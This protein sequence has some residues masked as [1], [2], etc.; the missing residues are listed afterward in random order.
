MIRNIISVLPLILLLVA[1]GGETTSP[2]P[3]PNPTTPEVDEHGLTTKGLAVRYKF[4]DDLKEATGS[5][6]DG[7]AQD[8]V[9]FIEG[10]SSKAGKAVRFNGFS[11]YV[12]VSG[13]K[14]SLLEPQDAFTFSFWI[15]AYRSTGFDQWT[16]ILSK[17][18]NFGKGYVF[19]W[20]HNGVSS[21]DAFL[22]YRTSG[23]NTSTD[24]LTIPNTQYLNRWTHVC[25]SWSASAGLFV[26]Y[27]DGV[28]AGVFLNG[29]YHG[30][31]S[32]DAFYIGG[33]PYTMP[34]G[35]VID[36]TVPAAIDDLRVYSRAL[37][38]DEIYALSQER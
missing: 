19:K 18:D 5:G 8:G 12:K 15:N 37:S 24:R 23:V 25:Y 4:D 21:L 20:S 13:S 29:L 11:G 9:T 30:E 36:R 3:T 1:C 31:H 22:I 38:Y 17:A 35:E 33:Q 14:I 27:I 10:R 2:T 34:N 28:A 32:G 7:V 26:V 6:L 16:H